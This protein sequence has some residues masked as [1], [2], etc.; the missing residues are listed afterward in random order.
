MRYEIDSNS[1]KIF[2]DNNVCFIYQ[3]HHPEKRPWSDTS[4]MGAWAEDYIFN[5][6]KNPEPT[7]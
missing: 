7:E 2:D 5:Y 1:V 6:G 3:P 4:E